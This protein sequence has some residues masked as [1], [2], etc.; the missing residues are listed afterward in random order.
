MAEKKARRR[1][2]LKPDPPPEPD[3]WQVLFRRF[4]SVHVDAL[5]CHLDR[6]LVRVNRLIRTKRMPNR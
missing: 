4:W 1:H 3:A 2:P 6:Q 5:E